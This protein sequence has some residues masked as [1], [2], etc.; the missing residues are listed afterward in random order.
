MGKI[1]RG[2]ST[3]FLGEK[4]IDFSGPFFDLLFG[5]ETGISRK[6]KLVFRKEKPVSRKE[7]LYL[8]RTTC[9]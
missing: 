9:I 5:R 7:L 3:S 2:P 8:V 6:E 4:Q 1:L